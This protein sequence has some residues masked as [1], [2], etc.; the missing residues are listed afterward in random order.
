[1]ETGLTRLVHHNWPLAHNIYT[2]SSEDH[3]SDASE[4]TKQ[5]NIA[6]TPHKKQLNVDQHRGH[7]SPTE[8]IEEFASSNNVDGESEPHTP[9]QSFP[10]PKEETAPSKYEN[11]SSL[12]ATPAP[13][14]TDELDDDDDFGDFDAFAD[15]NAETDFEAFDQGSNM[16]HPSPMRETPLSSHL[17]RC[18]LAEDM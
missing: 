5:C 14:N 8:T 11:K 16:L 13:E 17:V 4:G 6:S 12:Q 7:T 3:F 9:L 1:M 10:M 15:G 18:G 2:D